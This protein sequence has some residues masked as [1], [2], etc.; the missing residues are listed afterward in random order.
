[1]GVA[2]NNITPDIQHTTQ[3]IIKKLVFV[4]FGMLVDFFCVSFTTMKNEKIK[5]GRVAIAI[6]IR[7]AKT[8]THFVNI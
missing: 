6:A 1:M 8:R 4:S 5:N 7:Q 2:T 3:I